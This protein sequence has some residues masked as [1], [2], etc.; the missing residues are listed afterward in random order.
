M[1]TS[2]IGPLPQ[3][4]ILP[5]PTAR[6]RPPS[7]ETRLAR[8]LDSLQ[9]ALG[10][11]HAAAESLRGASARLRGTLQELHTRLTTYD[12]QLGRLADSL[13]GLGGESM[14]LECWADGVLAAEPGGIR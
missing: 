1:E 6:A 5:F 14:R 9:A 3:A 11:Q 2:D 8:A 12:G 7:P 10:E 4:D 13:A